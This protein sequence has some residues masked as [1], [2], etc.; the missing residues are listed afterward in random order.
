MAEPARFLSTTALRRTVAEGFVGAKIR[1]T[2]WERVRIREFTTEHLF[3]L[4]CTCF[5]QAVSKE[6]GYLASFE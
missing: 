4:T 6:I 3:S 5:I 2:P 1:F